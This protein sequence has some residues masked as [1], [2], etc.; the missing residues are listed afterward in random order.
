V[1]LGDGRV[2]NSLELRIQN[3]RDQP[4]AF[5]V[6]LVDAD[7]TELMVPG[8][9]LIVEAEATRQF[10]VFVLRTPELGGGDVT[11]RVHDDQG[12]TQD[13]AIEF[14]AGSRASGGGA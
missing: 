2:Q 13:I 3:R 11:L 7:G 14:L 5:T 8:G 4:R 1:S 6:E 10:P 12:F 9:T